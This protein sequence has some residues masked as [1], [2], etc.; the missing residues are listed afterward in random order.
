LARL[1]QIAQLGHSV[2][3][4]RA[5]PVSDVQD[6]VV[7]ELID[8]MMAT[9]AEA[10]GVGLAA[11]QV[12]QS[13]RIFI[14]ASQPNARYPDAPQMQPTAMLNPEIVSLSDKIE[15]DWEGCL[16]IPGIRGLVPRHHSLKLKYLTR[17]GRQVTEEF[18]GFIA[19]IIQ[20]EIDHLEGIF[21]L[22]R[23][24]NNR[25][26]V[27]EKEYLRIIREQR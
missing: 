18:T 22:D 19:C 9:V 15:K 14:I 10:Q 2:L 11:P 25:E 5:A 17:D 7:Q 27:S 16:S 8:D 21:F 24:E 1:L 12:Y 4:E 6:T 20:H 26:I 13:K 23:M 3:R